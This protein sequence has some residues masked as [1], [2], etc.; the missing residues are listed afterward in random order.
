MRKKLRKIIIFCLCIF[1][2][3]CL[4]IVYIFHTR[5]WTQYQVRSFSN[6]TLAPRE[7]AY[8]NGQY[9]YVSRGNLYQLSPDQEEDKY[10]DTF[11][12][13]IGDITQKPIV[14]FDNAIFGLNIDQLIRIEPNSQAQKE[15]IYLPFPKYD[16]I[17]DKQY[18][19]MTVIGDYMFLLGSVVTPSLEK[20]NF[21][22]FGENMSS[23]NLLEERLFNEQEKQQKICIKQ[24]GEY[25]YFYSGFINSRS[26]VGIADK[27]NNHIFFQ[28]GDYAPMYVDT[29]IAVLA[30]E[31]GKGMWLYDRKSQTLSKIQIPDDYYYNIDNTY[32]KDGYLYLLL[33]QEK[34]IQGH[35]NAAQ[36]YHK[37]D[38]LA[39]YNPKTNTIF[40][41]Y[42]TESKKERI[43]AMT[44]KY[45]Y[46]LRNN[47]LYQMSLSTQEKVKFTEIEHELMNAS[48]EVCQQRLF[49]WENNTMVFT[50]EIT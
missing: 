27:K 47:I 10:I 5:D 44:E 32:M 16:Q 9:F 30:G 43:V 42:K 36:A 50:V 20:N 23:L 2:V 40:Y 22:M 35:Y 38:I 4:C 28:A 12:H 39:R 46:L 31:Y 25:Q 7:C 21:V 37:R 18:M 14:S 11:N 48:F 33:H 3:L 19:N 41:L 15:V 26:I 13:S 17:I 45:I 49:V 29:D 1:L 6:N 34:D 8:N 24:S